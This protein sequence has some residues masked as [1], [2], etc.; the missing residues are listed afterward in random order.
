MAIVATIA[1]ASIAIGIMSTQSVSA[2]CSPDGRCTGPAGTIN[3]CIN[4]KRTVTASD[5]R[6]VTQSC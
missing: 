2:V 1:M 5:G 6:N 4:H 3:P